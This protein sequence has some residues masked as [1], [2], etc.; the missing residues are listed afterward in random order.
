MCYFAGQMTGVEGYVES[1]ASGL[2]AG[3]ALAAQLREEEPVQLPGITAMGAMGRY[4][5]TPNKHFQ[6]MN[7][8][9][10]LL[11]SLPVDKEHKKIRNKQQR[12]QVISDRAIQYMKAWAAERKLKPGFPTPESAA[13]IAELS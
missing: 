8:S 3:L 7:C 6:P 13:Q 10:G 1:A 5:S 4:V 11:D 12:Y 9:F 2:L